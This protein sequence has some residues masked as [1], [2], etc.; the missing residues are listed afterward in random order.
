MG[1]AKLSTS[2]GEDVLEK[3]WLGYDT[4]GD[5]CSI[6]VSR[7]RPQEDPP[8]GSCFSV[9]VLHGSMNSCEDFD[10]AE[11]PPAVELKVMDRH[12]VMNNEI[13]KV[14]LAKPEGYVTRIKYSGMKNVLQN[15]QEHDRGYWDIVCGQPTLKNGVFRLRATNF[16]IITQNESQVELSFSN[17][18]DPNSEDYFSKSVPLKVDIRY[19]MLSGRPGFYAY[20]IF[21]REEKWPALYVDQ[22]RIA[23]KLGMKK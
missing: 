19:I 21:E 3:I 10:G 18:W 5:C 20:A 11:P 15:N 9:G 8:N 17:T 23:F 16:S 1:Y 4:F 14:T 12:V 13:L 22:L 2:N 7:R 6:G